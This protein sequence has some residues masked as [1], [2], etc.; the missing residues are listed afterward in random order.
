M[1]DSPPPVPLLHHITPENRFDRIDPAEG[2]FG[3]ERARHETNYMVLRAAGQRGQNPLG[4]QQRMTAVNRPTHP[5]RIG[6]ATNTNN[7]VPHGG[8][9]DNAAAALGRL[10]AQQ[11]TLVTMGLPRQADK[12]AQL[13]LEPYTTPVHAPQDLPL[14]PHRLRATRSGNVLPPCT[15]HAAGEIGVSVSAPFNSTQDPDAVQI[16]PFRA[17]SRQLRRAA[18]CHGASLTL[19]R[20]VRAHASGLGRGPFGPALRLVLEAEDQVKRVV[21]SRRSVGTTGVRISGLVLAEPS[22][23]TAGYQM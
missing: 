18:T 10:T 16:V 12:A 4:V 6:G 23:I 19:S 15:P 22:F 11:A 1:P 9:A 3:L 13:T 17:L 8:K 5:V 2:A 21:T 20:M 7:Q 14:P